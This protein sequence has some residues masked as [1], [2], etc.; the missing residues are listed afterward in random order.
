MLA[1]L[2]PQGLPFGREFCA[3]WWLASAIFVEPS[4]F[5]GFFLFRAH[6]FKV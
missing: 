2:L 1:C 6:T 4:V 5:V 3:Q